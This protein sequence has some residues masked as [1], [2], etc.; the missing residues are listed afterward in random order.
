[1]DKA[2]FDRRRTEI[3]SVLPI[4]F[5]KPLAAWATLEYHSNG[6]GDILIG[7]E[8]IVEV[9]RDP[10]YSYAYFVGNAFNSTKGD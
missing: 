8:E 9:I 5:H 6:Y 7:L 3:L 1:M 10:V 4:Q 2:E